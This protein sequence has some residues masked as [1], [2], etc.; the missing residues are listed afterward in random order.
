[1]VFDIYYLIEDGMDVSIFSHC[2]E[3][4]LTGLVGTTSKESKYLESMLE[5]MRDECDSVER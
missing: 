4:A 5:S 1:M 3:L 2:I